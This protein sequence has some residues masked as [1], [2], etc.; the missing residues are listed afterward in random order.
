MLIYCRGTY[1]FLS[2]A[3]LYY[4]IFNPV[5]MMQPSVKLS[6]KGVQSSFTESFSKAMLVG[7][8][9]FLTASLW[10]PHGSV[11]QPFFLAY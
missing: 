9:L 3:Q 8:F 10:V 6:S 11:L 4:N 5:V 7:H 1:G 2:T